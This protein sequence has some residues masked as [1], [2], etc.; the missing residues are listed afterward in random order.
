MRPSI[1]Q[2]NERLASVAAPLAVAALTFSL[3]SW[4]PAQF[5]QA[6]PTEAVATTTVVQPV[7]VT[8]ASTSFTLHRSKR[9]TTTISGNVDNRAIAL[10]TN[11]AWAQTTLSGD[12]TLYLIARGTTC[13]GAA[14]VR[15]YVD[16]KRIKTITTTAANQFKEYRV[17]E[18]SG[19][20]KVRVKLINDKTLRKRCS[21][22]AFVTAVHLVSNVSVEVPNPDPEPGTPSAS[23]SDSPS[24][25]PSAPE[26]TT[27]AAPS[28]SASPTPEPTPTLT[29][30]PTVTPTPTSS[31]MTIA[32][33]ASKRASLVPG[34]YFPDATNTG[35][36]DARVLQSVEGNV[37][38]SDQGSQVKVIENKRFRGYVYLTGKNYL[39]RNC[40]FEG[41]ANPQYAAVIARYATSSGNVFEDSTFKPR[42]INYYN[43]TINGRGFTLKR[44]ELT[45]AVDGANPSVADGGTRVDVTIT[46]SWIHDLLRWSPDP[47]HSDNQ[48]H[49]DGIQWMGGLGLTLIGNRIEGLLDT[50]VSSWGPATYDASGK[51]TGGHPFYPNPVNGETL[52]VNAY[53]NKI[54]PG[55][56]TMRKNWIRGGAVGLNM[57]GAT[58]AW[59]KS[60]GSAIEENWFLNDQGYGKNHRM[61]AKSTQVI[62]T[63]TNYVW[64]LRNPLSKATAVSIRVNV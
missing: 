39:F 24:A 12:G 43:G 3:L 53:Q 4:S 27:S 14:K 6:A 42:G 33:I 46:G 25:T 1:P 41:P 11:K 49:S 40:L 58:S 5:A 52:M 64:D 26:P 36:I 57:L 45:G 2:L 13:K 9:V 20:H 23:P 28:E 35:L 54:Q 38:Y 44:V 7:K 48:S 21:R 32:E 47:T 55:E 22:D 34:S 51:M 15:V 37:T 18:F 56:L 19:T 30:S 16:G 63:S 62:S 17:T 60:D 10:R 59:A 29:P 31:P 50:S 8:K 61:V